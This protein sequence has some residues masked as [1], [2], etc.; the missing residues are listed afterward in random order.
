MAMGYIHEVINIPLNIQTFTYCVGLVI[1]KLYFASSYNI[2][3]AT[4]E[5]RAVA[6][7][8]ERKKR[9]KYQS[10]SRTHHFVPVA[11]ETSGAFNTN[12]YIRKA[13]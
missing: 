2:V 4:S 10:L 12:N 6:E 5:A 9:S 11:V 1:I 8:A 7:M 3:Q 13:H